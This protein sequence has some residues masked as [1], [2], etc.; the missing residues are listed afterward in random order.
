[1]PGKTLNA[2]YSDKLVA[3]THELLVFYNYYF[4]GCSK[5]VA[6]SEIKKIESL[7]PTVLNGKWRIW[8]SSSLMGWMPMDWN[9]PSRDRIFLLHYKNRKFQIGFTVEDS[10]KVRDILGEMG[11]VRG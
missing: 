6:V 4:W 1:M 8:G 11:L 10:F 9:R 3:I 5:T 7:A 2:L